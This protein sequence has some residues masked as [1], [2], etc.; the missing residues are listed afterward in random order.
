MTFPQTVIPERERLETFY[1]VDQ[2]VADIVRRNG[3][4]WRHEYLGDFLQRKLKR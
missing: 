1:F 3:G 4:W 2:T